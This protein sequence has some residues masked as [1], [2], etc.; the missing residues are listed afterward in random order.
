MPLLTFKE[1]DAELRVSQ[2][3][4]QY[5]LVELGLKAKK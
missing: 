5:W 3:W 2:Q 4:L 1:A